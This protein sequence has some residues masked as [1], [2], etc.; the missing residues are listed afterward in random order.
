[1]NFSF[2]GRSH[3]SAQLAVLSLA[4]CLVPSFHFYS[5]WPL[6]FLRDSLKMFKMF[7]LLNC[8]CQIHITQHFHSIVVCLEY[9][10]VQMLKDTNTPE[11]THV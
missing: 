11:W 3:L 2:P 10:S 1:M 6:L 8:L 7:S 5:Q 4:M 9:N